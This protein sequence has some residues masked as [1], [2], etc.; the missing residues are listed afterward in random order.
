MQIELKRGFTS[1]AA[2]REKEW[3][4]SNFAEFLCGIP[5]KYKIQIFTIY[6]IR[7]NER[8]DVYPTG[9]KFHDIKTGERGVWFGQRYF[10]FKDVLKLLEK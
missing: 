10:E 7:I 4:L 3:I 8:L 6:H 9:C 1:E 5:S 2:Q